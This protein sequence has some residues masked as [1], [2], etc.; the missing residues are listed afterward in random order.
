[1]MGALASE[2]I[3]DP[4]SGTGGMAAGTPV[5]KAQWLE[6]PTAWEE[7]RMGT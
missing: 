1:M 5:V 3:T 6:A 2:T 7:A 4:V